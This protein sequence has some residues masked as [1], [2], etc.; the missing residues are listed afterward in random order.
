[1]RVIL[2]SDWMVMLVAGRTNNL[3]SYYLFDANIT[4]ELIID[5]EDD[6]KIRLNFNVK[7]LL[8]QQPELVNVYPVQGRIIMVG[9]SFYCFN[10]FTIFP[11]LGNKCFFYFHLA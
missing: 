3:E 7:N 2:P 1:M 4:R 5:E 11:S 9:I 10:H 6:R 8:N